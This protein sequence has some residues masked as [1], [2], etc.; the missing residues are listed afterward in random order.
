VF[1]FLVR[2][3]TTI[4]LLGVF[5]L[6]FGLWSYRDLPRE[7]FPEIKI[8]IIMVSTPYVGVSPADVEALITTKLESEL[9]SLTD[10]R[11]MTS[12]SSEG[13]SLVA[14]EFEPEVDLTEALQK[15]RDRVNRA[16]TKLPEDAEEPTVQEV[17]FSNFPILLV[18]LTGPD[19]VK[20]KKIAENLEDVLTRVPGVLGVDIA[21]GRKRQVRVQV[22]PDRLGHYGLSLNDVIGA[23]GSENVNIPGGTVTVGEGSFLLRTPSEVLDPRELERVALK[24]I[25]DRPVFLTDVARVVDG[26]EERQTVSRMTGESSVTL[27]VKK[28]TGANVL[29]M[30]QGVKAAVLAESARWPAGVEHHILSD[31]SE[32]IEIMVADLENNIIAALLLVVGIVLLAMGPRPAFFVALSIPLSMAATFVS[33]GTLGYTLNTVVLFSLVLALGMLVDNAIVVVEN[34][35]RH[36][37]MG[38]TSVEA[39]ID[40]VEEV[41]WP[42]TG[43]TLTTVAAFLP[44]IWW[45][46]CSGR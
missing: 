7:N 40:G 15:V 18:T 39:A 4:T 41:F 27:A 5:V 14:I 44:L 36:L 42:V 38:K 34:I 13:F 32:D 33:L 45:T 46:R 20:L 12:S 28:R 22:D 26:F 9:A 24:R 31:Q 21:G 23:I 2:H 10:V 8:P 11:K 25:G 29:Q 37:E 43:S 19:E 1:R 17:S 3:R 35:Y 16:R 30:A 6:F